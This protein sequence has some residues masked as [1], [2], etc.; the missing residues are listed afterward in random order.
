M[1]EINYDIG[2]SVWKGAEE[3]E[4]CV[5]QKLSSLSVVLW[6]KYSI[7]SI[8]VIMLVMANIIFCCDVNSTNSLN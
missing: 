1:Y 2:K 5:E 7:Q 6:S 8:R 3:G 4:R